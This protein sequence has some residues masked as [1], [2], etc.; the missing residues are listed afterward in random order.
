[1]SSDGKWSYNHRT[2]DERWDCEYEFD[3]EQEAVD[4]ARAAAKEWADDYLNDDC[5]SAEYLDN[6]KFDVG[7]ITSP[8]YS[9]DAEAVIEHVQEQVGEQCGECAENW[10]EPPYCYWDKQ[11][12]KEARE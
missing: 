1:M 3:T 6:G 10:L 5:E 12:K 9:I 8:V 11:N 7:Q 2:D 4:A